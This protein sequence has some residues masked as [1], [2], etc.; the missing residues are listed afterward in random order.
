MTLLDIVCLSCTFKVVQQQLH[1]YFMAMSGVLS[2]VTSGLT[3]MTNVDR[4]RNASK[5]INFLYVY[6]ELIIL[7]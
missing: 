7:V 3:S 4:A 1:D 6:V 5:S 2:Y